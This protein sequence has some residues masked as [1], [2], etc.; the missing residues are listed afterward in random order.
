MQ[1]FLPNFCLVQHLTVF[2]GLLGQ[3]LS[4]PFG[5]LPF[6]ISPSR[7][8]VFSL[9]S[10]SGHPH[11][12]QKSPFVFLIEVSIFMSSFHYPPWLCFPWYCLG[13]TSYPL[14][15]FLKHHCLL[16]RILLNMLYSFQAFLFLFSMNLYLIHKLS[17]LST[18]P[19]GP[20]ETIYLIFKAELLS[21]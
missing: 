19:V 6:S 5:L 18:V 4:L 2:K 10:A 16:L 14:N 17:L 7:H 3:V 21:A 1:T 13:T 12:V 8:F 20:T 9:F 11:W 15:I